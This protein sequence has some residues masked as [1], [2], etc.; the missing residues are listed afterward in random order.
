MGVGV[1][2]GEQ[3]TGSAGALNTENGKIPQSCPLSEGIRRRDAQRRHRYDGETH[4]YLG[5]CVPTCPVYG[6]TLPRVP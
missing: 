3:S 2:R 1:A 6:L 4:Q 5:E